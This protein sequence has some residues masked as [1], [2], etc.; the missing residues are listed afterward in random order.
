[1]ETHLFSKRKCLL[2]SVPFVK[3]LFVCLFYNCLY[4][5]FLFI[6]HTS[7]CERLLFP[8]K[9]KRQNMFFVRKR[10]KSSIYWA[11]EKFKQMLTNSS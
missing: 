8:L 5:S 6:E 7:V 4:N 11:I 1:M 2:I 3:G 10:A 9:Q